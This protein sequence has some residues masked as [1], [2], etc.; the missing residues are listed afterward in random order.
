MG[1]CMCASLS[2]CVHISVTACV[3]VRVCE[4]VQ[5]PV[6]VTAWS[7]K[8]ELHPSSSPQSAPSAVSSSCYGSSS[9]GCIHGQRRKLA[10]PNNRPPT[11]PLSPSPPARLLTRWWTCLGVGGQWLRAAEWQWGMMRERMRKRGVTPH[12]WGGEMRKW[13]DETKFDYYQEVGVW[14]AILHFR[15]WLL[16]CPLSLKWRWNKDSVD[17]PC[18][19]FSAFVYCAIPYLCICWDERA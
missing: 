13:K 9:E 6:E 5:V 16:F 19:V 14:V 3:G 18:T 2:L 7:Q 12:R 8:R 11:P 10:S 4:H 17:F 1:L 15:K